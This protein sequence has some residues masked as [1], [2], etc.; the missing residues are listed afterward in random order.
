MGIA[1]LTSGVIALIAWLDPL[2]GFP[3]SIGGIILGLVSLLKYKDQRKRAVG[4]IF[5]SFLGLIMT[6]IVAIG[7]IFILEVGWDWETF[8]NTFN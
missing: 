4:S 8:Q 3:V 7:I 6:I 1:S 2:I 5:L